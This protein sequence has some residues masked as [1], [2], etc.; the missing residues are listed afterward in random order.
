[1]PAKYYHNWLKLS[2]KNIRAVKFLRF[3]ENPRKQ[4]IILPR[5]FPNIRYTT[6]LEW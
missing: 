2:L 5:K 4:Q 3:Q 1:M 6:K